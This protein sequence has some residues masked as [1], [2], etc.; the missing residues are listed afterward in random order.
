MFRFKLF[1]GYQFICCVLVLLVSSGCF[2]TKEKYNAKEM[3]LAKI[4]KKYATQKE[5]AKEI[6]QTLADMIKEKGLLETKSEEY[7]SQL[8]EIK[9]K[10]DTSEE[11]K[12][13]HSAQIDKLKS[14]IKETEA[15]LNE[16]KSKIDALKNER[17]NLLNIV[18]A[19][20]ELISNVQTQEERSRFANPQDS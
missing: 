10:Y 20:K 11:E 12:K 1:N 4:E 9:T 7:K 8:T 5:K 3:E 17:D 6:Q 14:Q 18:Q 15:R 2:V 19:I 16:Q 13:E